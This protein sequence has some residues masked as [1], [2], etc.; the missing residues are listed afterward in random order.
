MSS[1]HFVARTA[2][3]LI[4]KNTLVLRKLWTVV[5]HIDLPTP[6]Q[7]QDDANQTTAPDGA[8]APDSSQPA[9]PDGQSAQGDSEQTIA[10]K[11]T[12]TPD[13]TQNPTPNPQPSDA[14]DLSGRSDTQDPTPDRTQN[15]TPDTQVPAPND[16]EFRDSYQLIS[17]I[18]LYDMTL[19]RSEATKEDETHIALR[20]TEVI[21]EATYSLYHRLPSGVEFPVFIEVPFTTLEDHGDETEEPTAEGWESPTF[22]AGPGMVSGDEHLLHHEADHYEPEGSDDWWNTPL[23]GD[24]SAPAPDAGDDGSGGDQEI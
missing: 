19:P 23:P 1:S 11:H 2:E 5:V 3:G 9:T 14:S 7:P 4:H 24:Q 13:S 16:M 22:E 15:P 10:P 12:A 20:F 21:P 18:G 17:D 8:A 6:Q